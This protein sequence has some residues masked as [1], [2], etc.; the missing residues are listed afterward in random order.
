[1]P[2]IIRCVYCGGAE[3]REAGPGVSAVM[4]ANPACQH[5]YHYAPGKPLVDVSMTGPRQ[6]PFVETKPPAPTGASGA[7]SGLALGGSGASGSTFEY[8]EK[9]R[10]EAFGFEWMEKERERRRL[11]GKELTDA[12][13]DQYFFVCCENDAECNKPCPSHRDYDPRS[14]PGGYGLD[15]GD[16]FGAP[17]AWRPFRGLGG[18]IA[19]MWWPVLEMILLIAG[20]GASVWSLWLHFHP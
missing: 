17:A 9:A 2:N 5:W 6:V 10:R 12:L 3:F 1:M 8:L 16:I 4:C 13:D 15:D 14:G 7:M 20:A 19:D 11:A 18:W